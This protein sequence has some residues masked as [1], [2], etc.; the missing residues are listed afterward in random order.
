MSHLTFLWL[1]PPVPFSTVLGTPPRTHPLAPQTPSP[2]ILE[3]RPLHAQQ[4]GLSAG[5]LLLP[6]EAAGDDGQA[7]LPQGQPH[8]GVTLQ[9]APASAGPQAK[10][11]RQGQDQ[12]HG[13][14]LVTA[15]RGPS[16][17]RPRGSGGVREA[18]AEGRRVS[19]EHLLCA[20]PFQPL[21]CIVRQTVSAPSV[22]SK[23]QWSTHYVPG[24]GEPSGP[25]KCGVSMQRDIPSSKGRKF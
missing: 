15:Q 11:Q 13:R 25:T 2:R 4:Q 20:R 22:Y 7:Q 9:A 14:A 19:A 18:G 23:R 5:H 16:R 3:E 10:E 6:T 24:T 21:Q 17:P 1:A 8:G 12:R